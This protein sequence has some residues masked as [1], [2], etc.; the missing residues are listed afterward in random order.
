MRLHVFA[1][2]PSSETLESSE[3]PASLPESFEFDDEPPH[4]TATATQSD[5]PNQ[6]LM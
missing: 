5:A 1:E 2:L 6:T 4:A 3:C